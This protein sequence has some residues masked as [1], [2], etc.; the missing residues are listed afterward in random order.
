M[1]LLHSNHVEYLKHNLNS[2]IMLL[3]IKDLYTIR[4]LQSSV[5]NSRERE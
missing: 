3:Q 5:T 4:N 2:F 1:M